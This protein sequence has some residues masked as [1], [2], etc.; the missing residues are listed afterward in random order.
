MK[1][2]MLFAVLLLILP[3]LAC[4]FSVDT[5]GETPEP[6][7]P[8][9]P[10]KEAVEP[11]PP[12]L[13]TKALPTLVPPTTEPPPISGPNFYDVGFA[14]GITDDGQPVGI[15]ERFPPGTTPVY[16][17]A[18]Y[19]GMRD[20][21]ECESV[22]YQDGQERVRDPFTWS[23]GESGGPLWIANVTNE[24][25][26]F[27]GEYTWELY[28]DG[29]LMVRASFVIGEE[30]PSPIL[31]EDDFSDPGSGWEIGD[32]ET[33]SVGYRDGAYFVTSTVEDEQMW[34]VANQSFRD[35][36]IDVD[37]TQV[38]GPS[39][40]N[41]AYGVMC[42]VQPGVRDGY[43][44]VISGDGFCSIYKIVDGDVESLADWAESETIRQGNATNH[45]RAVCD[46]A[47]LALFVNGELVAEASDSTFQEGDIALTVT[48]F[49]A[50][51]TEVLFD[52]L[53][54]DRPAPRP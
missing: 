33:G 29:D 36:V 15:A 39:N 50:E 17:F 28:V 5:A 48:T 20:G 27:P 43:M 35:L 51:S 22:W 25:G 24:D 19:D 10:T 6:T 40:D 3:T 49:E 13:P 12:P 1:K 7:T 30:L 23:L 18:S 45:L 11:T 9:P 31:F 46:G 26:L 52:D 8:P 37:A 34:G 42:R 14:A 21:L 54:V 47:D 44:L 2:W 32:Y 16:A 41:N 38:S 4:S 53:T